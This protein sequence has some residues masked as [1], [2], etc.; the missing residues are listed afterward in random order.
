[1]DRP[2]LDQLDWN[3]LRALAAVLELGSLTR[4][5]ERLGLSQPTL[6]RQIAELEVQLGAPLFERTGRRLRRTALADQL[7]EPAERMQVAARALGPLAQQQRG[8]LAG[9][10]RITASEVVAAYVLPR[11]LV[12][13]AERHPDIEIELV[14]S[15]RID[16]LLEREADLAVRMVAPQ[17]GS[18]IARS[19]GD[20]ALGFYVHRDYLARVGGQIEPARMASYRW[21]GLD[22]NPQL[23]DG[24]QAAGYPIDRHFFALRS[25]NMMVGVEAVRAGLGIG[26]LSQP[27]AERLPELLRVLPDQP[28]PSLPVWLVTHREL[29]TSR[30]LRAVFD[31]LA[32]R[33]QALAQR[34]PL[35]SSSAPVV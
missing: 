35:T 11:L 17:Q 13:L 4:A 31:L 24:F 6:S 29:H 22:S 30:R 5:A 12:E 32:E 9:T 3:L 33:L 10:V 25:D 19:L 7:Q 2:E 16:N 26:L 14:A 23:I 21:I 28:L 8:T 34:P 15:N 27:V 18:V 1:M 20:W